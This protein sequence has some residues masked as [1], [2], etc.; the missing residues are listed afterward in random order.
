[1]SGMNPP[2]GITTEHY[3]DTKKCL[4]RY[5]KS[6]IFRIIPFVYKIWVSKV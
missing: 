2:Y 1:M 6:S 5:A 4:L 3:I